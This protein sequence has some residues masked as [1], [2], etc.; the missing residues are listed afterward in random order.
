[1]DDATT[2]LLA[3]GFYEAE[4]T[5]AHMRT[6]RAHLEAHGRPV[7]YYS[8]RYSVF[9]VNRKR[10]A[11]SVPTQFSR[12]LRTLDIASI[13]A[14]SPQAKGRVERANQTL[15]DRLVKEMRL[16]GIC[17]M[18]AG[19][20]YLPEFMADFNR[21]FAVAPRNAEDAHREV[22]HDAGE[23]DSDPVRAARRAS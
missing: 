6:T 8:D 22:P 11:R 19:N 17:G 23:L 9:R 16:R 12:A 21:R 10:S 1:M 14:R 15:Q 2:R 4:T 3:T 18:A 13:H 7:A 5:E 20:A